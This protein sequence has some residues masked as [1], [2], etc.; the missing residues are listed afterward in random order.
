MVANIY[1]Q[2]RENVADDTLILERAIEV[3]TQV[4][5]SSHYCVIITADV[6]LCDAVARMSGLI[7][8]RVSPASLVTPLGEEVTKIMELLDQQPHNFNTLVD[9]A[10]FARFTEERLL[11]VFVDTGAVQHLL[12]KLVPEVVPNSKKKRKG[13]FLKEIISLSDDK[14]RW[15]K[16]AL[17][18]VPIKDT[19]KIRLRF[20]EID[21][22]GRP[23]LSLHKP[24][25][26]YRTRLTKYESYRN[27]TSITSEIWHDSETGSASNRSFA[28][29]DGNFIFS[30]FLNPDNLD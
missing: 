2:N 13:L 12:E 25:L 9:L 26:P 5:R 23:A 29:T 7:V 16:V 28:G 21:I 19:K 3:G 15:E 22:L 20:D 27:P 14:S 24:D 6:K 30:P 18:E 4:T 8:I 1:Y 10:G 17:T 11:D